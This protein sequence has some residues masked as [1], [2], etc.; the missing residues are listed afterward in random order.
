MSHIY[1]SLMYLTGWPLAVLLIA[2][3]LYFT[4]KTRFIQ[5]RLFVESLRVVLEKPKGKESISSFGALM[6]STASRVGTGNIIGVSTAIC[7]G[8]SGA[9]FWMWLTALIGGASAFVESTLAQIYKRRN[10]DGS[11]YGGP[12]FYIE[13]ACKSKF[14]AVVFA[15]ALI[16]TYGATPA[17]T[18]PPPWV[19]SSARA[20]TSPPWTS[21]T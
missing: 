2:G 16:F 7:F 6:I 13:S 10:P 9:V 11:C 18:A 3:G 14:F 5:L 15:V 1:N 12:S 8:G 19:R 4:F 20:T 21:L 17:R